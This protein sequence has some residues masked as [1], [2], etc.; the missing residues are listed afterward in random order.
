MEEL[1]H[2]LRQLPTNVD[3][4]DLNEPAFDRLLGSKDSPGFMLWDLIRGNRVRGKAG[5]DYVGMG[6]TLTSKV[7][8]RKRP[9]LIPI[10]D[11]KIKEKIQL[12]HS[13]GHW[14]GMWHALTDQGGEL[15]NRLRT[16]REKSDQRQI[17]LLRT[18]DVAV[19]HFAKEPRDQ[20]SRPS[21]SKESEPADDDGM[22]CDAADA[23]DVAPDV[24]T[25]Q[26]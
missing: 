11:S 25:L 22:I 17:S 21:A 19:W 4:G 15:A 20:W 6:A 3:L 2:H 26:K 16:I 14:E 24:K 9:R 13:G 7:L 1:E 18:F 23:V 8:A 12:S 10:W 5:Q